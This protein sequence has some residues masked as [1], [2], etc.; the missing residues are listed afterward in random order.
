SE[1]LR[2]EVELAEA[3]R[4]TELSGLFVLTAGQ[5]SRS[6][7]TQV[8]AEP[9]RQLFERLRSEY[10]F[11]L[12]DS[13]PVLP[14]ADSLLFG[15][16]VDAAVLTIRPRISRSP[17]VC[18]AYERLTSVRISVLGAVVNAV[19]SYPEKDYYRYYVSPEKTA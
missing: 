9:G 3:I 18:D 4:T 6:V 14:V 8:S 2:G 17:L 16:H 5:M 12:V 10:D 19:R 11:V 7:L 13:C 15:K 1:V